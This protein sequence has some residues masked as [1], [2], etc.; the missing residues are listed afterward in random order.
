VESTKRVLLDTLIDRLIV[1]QA[2]R[3]A[4]ITATPEEVDR[5][6]MRISSDYAAENFN[7][8]LAQ[9]QQSMAELKQRTAASLTIE[10]YYQQ[11]VYARVAVTE[12]EIRSYYESHAKEFEVPEMVRAEQ[13][14]VKGL[15]EARRIQAQLKT[16]KKFSDLA[17]KYSLSA[18]AK[19]GGDLGFF[20]RGVMPPQFDEVAFKLPVGQVSDVVTTDY[21]YHLFTVLERRPGRKRELSEVRREVE[22]K[23][24]GEKRLQ[25]QLEFVKS[26]RGRAQVKVNEPVLASVTGKPNRE[27]RVAEP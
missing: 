15:D 13:L 3:A 22:H 2:A 20:P 25:A 12:Q 6:V 8:A 26:E 19:V 7:E 18:D 21:G 1:L 10:K 9:G 5:R 16:G 24:L 14:V 27:P 4:N 23:L 11:N 17:R